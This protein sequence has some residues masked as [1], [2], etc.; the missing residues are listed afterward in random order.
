MFGSSLAYVTWLE[1][2]RGHKGLP[3]ISVDPIHEFAQRSIDGVSVFFA[4][5]F[6]VRSTDMDLSGIREW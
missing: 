6:I 3:V 1:C 2:Q 4:H 5:V